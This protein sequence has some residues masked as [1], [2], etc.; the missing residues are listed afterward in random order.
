MLKVEKKRPSGWLAQPHFPPGSSSFWQIHSPSSCLTEGI[1][2]WVNHTD[3]HTDVWRHFNSAHLWATCEGESR[4]GHQQMAEKQD[5]PSPSCTHHHS[6]LMGSLAKYGF[7]SRPEPRRCFSNCV[8]ICSLLRVIKVSRIS[9]LQHMTSEYFVSLPFCGKV[10][11]F[12]CK[13]KWL[14]VEVKAVTWFLF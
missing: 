2:A 13:G 8:A 7:T 5:R 14:R 9:V 6:L 1:S 11:L 3:L 10:C 12:H 4:G